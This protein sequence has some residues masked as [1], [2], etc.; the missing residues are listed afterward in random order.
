MNPRD[1]PFAPG[2]GTQPPELAG[3]SGIITDAEVAL[4]RARRGLGK[5]MLLLGLRGV[6]KTVLLN[7]VAEMAEA[8]GALPV[9]LEAPEDQTLAPMLVPAL[10]STLFSLSASE[11]AG[12]LTKRGFGVLRSFA[13][14]FKVK[15]GEVEFG[16]KAEPGK[17]DSG[18]LEHDLPALLETVA[19]AA[20]A[21]DRALVLFIDEVQYLGA[22]DLSALIVATHKLGQKG[23]PFLLVGAG[24]PQLAALAGEAKSY[25]ERLF[26][27][28]VVGPL[29]AQAARDAVAAPLKRESLKIEEAALNHIIK[30]TQGYPFF[31]Q[32]WGYQAWNAAADSPINLADVRVAEKAAIERLDAGFFK[33][34][35]DRLTPREREY[36]HTMAQLGPGPHRS[37]EVAK[38]LHKKVTAVGPLRDGLIKKGMIYSPQ[39]GDTAFT[40]PMFDE[41]LKRTSR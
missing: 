21:D 10:R 26:D 34:R 17:A 9:V 13:A 8:G 38:A 3:R 32:E 12:A 30:K 14:A 16:V 35:L 33:V 23:L 1:N 11:K 37:G 5:S 20:K 40:V 36:M 29:P 39:H 27:F 31:L 24:L 19:L 25:A 2:A 15:V 28:P 18:N 6:G 41:F 22:V 7:R 4:A